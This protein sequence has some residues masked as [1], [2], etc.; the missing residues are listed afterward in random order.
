[1]ASYDFD[2]FVIGAGSG[3]VRAARMSAGFGAR[4]AIAEERYY[5]GTCVN[6]GCIPKKLLVY[7]SRFSE[8]VAV[9]AGYGWAVPPARFAWPDLIRNKDVEITRLNGAYQRLLKNADCELIDGRAVLR[10]AHTLCIGDR[11]ITA[12]H[13]LVATGGWPFVPDLPGHEHAITSNEAFHLE[14]LPQRMVI[15][16]GG[17]IAVE[18]A[19]I[20]KGLDCEVTQIYRGPLFLRGFDAELRAFLAEQMRD[21][22][23]ALRFEAEVVG[24]AKTA[25]G[26]SLALADGTRLD[27]DGVMFATGRRPNTRG[28]GLEQ[29][30][31]ALARDGAIEVDAHYRSSVP[32]IYAIGDV[33]D[34]VNLTPVALAEGMS[35][36]RQLFGG[37]TRPVD[38]EFIPTAVFSQPPIGT[39]GY[40]EDDA[41]EQFGEIA[42]YTSRFTPLRYTLSPVKEQTLMKLV[43]EKRTDRVVGLH[44]CGE[45]A[46]EIVQGFAVAMRAGATKAIFD[47]TIGIHPTAAE[48]FVTMREAAR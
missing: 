44:M 30:G 1:M 25:R 36:A 13:I 10:D 18:F 16:G 32:S 34:R 22:G 4:V 24:I 21:Q 39:V 27:C 45:E 5:G 2:L 47:S 28:F 19:G 12:E 3:G 42:V 23:I 38:Y 41:R 11:M 20:F 15:V 9:A 17:Y 35:L 29:L 43:V 14:T 8:D 6:V 46:A 33:T 7:A 26:L 48:E 40:T 37:E 31:V